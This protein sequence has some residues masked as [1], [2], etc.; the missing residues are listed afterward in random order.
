MGPHHSRLHRCPPSLACR[1][2]AP[3]LL[4]RS[5]TAVP[6]KSRGA[7]A[8]AQPSK[9]ASKPIS[10]FAE[11]F[12]DMF[13]GCGVPTATHSSRG[14][15]SGVRRRP[16]S[17]TDP[18]ADHAAYSRYANIGS[19][20]NDCLEY[21]NE[22]DASHPWVV[23]LD[24]R[25]PLSPRHSA[26]ATACEDEYADLPAMVEHAIKRQMAGKRRLQSSVATR[27]NL[28]KQPDGDHLLFNVKV[29]DVDP[30]AQ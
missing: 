1:G 18:R 25:P 12:G 14:A 7:E 27:L 29:V 13:C 10:I 11:S 30:R 16:S 17:Q 9:G 22:W 4:A 2:Y 24:K 23:A 15:G 6:T 19:T 3:R 28:L 21:H 26:P 8:P 20:P 5:R